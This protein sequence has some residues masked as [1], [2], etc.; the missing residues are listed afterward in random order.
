MTDALVIGAGPAGLMAAEALAR[1][2]RTVTVAEAM[3]SPARKFLMA[4]KSGLNLTKDEPFDSFLAAYADAAPGLR[5]MLEQFG[6]TEVQ[7]WARGLGQE[8]FTGSSGRVFPTVMKASPLLRAWL[9]RLGDMDVTLNRR[10]RWTGWDGTA[11]TFDTP[12]GPRTLAPAVTVLA[13]GGASWARLGSDGAWADW[14]PGTAPFQP[15]N[16]ALS[17]PWSAHMRPHFGQPLKAVAWRAGNTTSRGEAVISA[18]GIEGGGLYH[19]TPALRAGATLTLDMVPDIDAETLA[20]RLPK[21]PR[22]ARLSHWLKNTLRLPAA[23]SALVFEMTGGAGQL[24]M[25]RWPE[26]LK[27]LAIANTALRP[28]DEA[29]STAG[30]LRFDALDQGLMVKSRPGTFAAGEML[31]W[32]APTGGYLITACLA[33]GLWA[34]RH[35]ARFRP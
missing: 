32:E 26:M 5:P 23:K 8:L 22:K 34:G 13:C 6:P 16:A 11:V 31:D 25:A 9:A 17:V 35:A 14:T 4:G 28:L 1:A 18:R 19:L 10:W 30:G 33:T 24:P 7:A 3:P 21:N 12:D 15:A 27:S 29:I 20:R 2:G